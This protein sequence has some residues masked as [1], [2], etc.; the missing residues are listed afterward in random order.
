LVALSRLPFRIRHIVHTNC[1]F[2]TTTVSITSQNTDRSSRITS[3]H[4]SYTNTDW[5]IKALVF[6]NHAVTLA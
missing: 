5:L 3:S 4:K 2:L 6:N 1:L